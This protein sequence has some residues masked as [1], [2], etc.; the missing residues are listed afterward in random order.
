MSE[1]RITAKVHVEKYSNA[2][3]HLLEKAFYDMKAGDID[4]SAL[5]IELAIERLELMRSACGLTA[6]EP[7]TKEH[8][9][10]WDKNVEQMSMVF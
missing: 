10:I 5:S 2:C 7:K 8:R 9:D 1:G 3:R 6:C 4:Q